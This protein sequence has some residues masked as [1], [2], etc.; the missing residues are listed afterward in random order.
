MANVKI[1]GLTSLAAGS[2]DRA[3][4]VLEI[5][6]VSA[7][8][9]KKITPNAL[10][11][12]S[13]S[14]VGDTDSQTLTNKT[15]TAP[16]ISSPTFSGT[17]I[18]TYTIGGTPTFPSSVAT[19]TGSQTLTNK[20]LTSPTINAATISNPTLT[21][22]SINE[23]TASN[24]VTVASVNIKSG[25]LNT[26]NSVPNNTLSNTG[27]FGSAWAW[28][29]WVPSFTNFTLGNGTITYAKYCQ[30]GKSIFYR[31]KIVLGS[32]SV[33][34]ISPIFS[35]PVTASSSYVAGDITHMT[36]ELQDFTG[37]RWFATFYYQT[38]TTVEITYLNASA[39]IVG[40]TATA[41]FTWAVS[42]NL[43]LNGVY[44]AA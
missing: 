38:S 2:V 43:A 6:D 33:M 4:D 18:G 17:L 14:A 30:V 8:Q 37:A 1:T 26:N 15:I 27:T 44:E 22:D 20:V 11:G 19:L 28:T 3:V 32:T 16:T 29:S 25:V 10:M 42:D 9:S 21:V 7:A 34:G 39:N 5:A 40:I 41:P 23:F 13:G 24:G 35:L 36:G 31:L 12:I